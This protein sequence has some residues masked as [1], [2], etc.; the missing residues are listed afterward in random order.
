MHRSI[1]VATNCS[2]VSAEVQHRSRKWNHF[3]IQIPQPHPHILL[4]EDTRL[5]WKHL[6]ECTWL[7]LLT[8]KGNILLFRLIT[9]SIFLYLPRKRNIHKS[10]KRLTQW[11][12]IV[13]RVILK[14]V[15]KFFVIW[16]FFCVCVAQMN[17]RFCGMAF[18]RNL[19]ACKL[20]IRHF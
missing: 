16:G 10:H 14:W 9:T 1:T 5:W 13:F 11:L 3:I 7:V 2:L 20:I 4:S 15:L 6:P 17:M 18:V 8:L 19:K 12:E